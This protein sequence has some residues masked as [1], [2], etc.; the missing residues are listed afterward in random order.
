M[1]SRGGS[2]VTPEEIAFHEQKASI[3]MEVMS[4]LI[5]DDEVY[6]VAD[7]SDGLAPP[8]APVSSAHFRRRL[9]AN[10]VLAATEDYLWNEA[11]QI[12]QPNA[13]AHSCLA[14]GYLGE[15]A[16]VHPAVAR[17]LEAAVSERGLLFQEPAPGKGV[18]TSKLK[19]VASGVALF[20][21]AEAQE[22]SENL[23]RPTTLPEAVARPATMSSEPT[24]P[25]RA[26]MFS[27]RSFK[28]DGSVRQES[29]AFDADPSLNSLFATDPVRR[30]AVHHD[31]MQKIRHSAG[32]GAGAFLVSPAAEKP[33]LKDPLGIQCVAHLH[34]RKWTKLARAI[35]ETIYDPN[36]YDDGT[37][38][39]MYVRLAIHGA[40]TW[41]RYDGTGGLEGAAMRFKPEY[42]D[43]HNK[44]CKEIIARQHELIK[45]P[46]PW[47][48]YA[49]I[50]CLSAYVALEC[51]NGPV[52]P[53]TPGRRDVIQPEKLSPEDQ[54]E[55]K[56]D[57][58][59]LLN[60]RERGDA[61]CED[62][63]A[64]AV[65]PASGKGG[66][67]C[68]FL[69]KMK[70]LPGRVPG[71]EQGHLGP[72][73]QPVTPE[74]EKEEM[75]EVAHHIR[76]IF[77]DRMGVSDRHTVALIAGGHSLGRC[78]P[79]ISGYAGPWQSN[80]GYFNNDYCKKLLTED[81]KLVDRNMK[82]CSGDVITG[83]K[84]YGMRRQ[85]VNKGGRG[86]LMMLVSDM[87]LKV[88]P[89][90]GFWIKEYARDGD[91]LKKDFGDAFKAATEFGFEPPPPARGFAKAL[92]TLRKWEADAL[93]WIGT[94]I[95]CNDDGSAK[96]GASEGPVFLPDDA[97]KVGQPYTL[98]E[99]QQHASKQ[100][101]WVAING[102]V[103]D[104]TAFM[105][106]HPGG[107]SVIMS[108]AGK[109]VTGMWNAIHGPDMIEKI[110]PESVIGYLVE[111]K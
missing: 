103:C 1:R 2:E 32:D 19:T 108:N 83:L 13:Q 76:E 10:E 89:E 40:A 16:R 23:A 27:S 109:D 22:A 72:A 56:N 43:A 100:D 26:F 94:H 107:E 44:F 15:E 87:A 17:A 6:D 98:E 69:T 80:P 97:P 29:S 52:I 62:Q 79:Q 59:V 66:G 51:A 30:A 46:F 91:L 49:D 88:D 36:F 63:P 8:S 57:D 95:C 54:Q 65:C 45:V 48:S 7:G 53:F 64:P 111:S 75:K 14:L 35:R 99:V 21:Q 105:G 12:S 25:R 34:D 39:P 101:C 50:Q 47:V 18:F 60:Y 77:G 20:E 96:G 81:W 41:D 85:Y 9:L 4:K 61:G 67:E 92:F 5:D 68:P 42:S 70:V 28:S 110:A 82:D 33:V 24:R 102:K 71:P 58:F 3:A 86:N 31:E 78:H 74:M 104:L 37:Y 84:P 38:G 55:L 73:C 106:R 90:Y 93:R 11:A